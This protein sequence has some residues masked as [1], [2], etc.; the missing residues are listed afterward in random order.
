[1]YVDGYWEN[2][3]RVLG[4]VFVDCKITTWRPCENFLNLSG[5]NG[6][7]GGVAGGGGASGATPPA[8]SVQDAAK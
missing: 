5:L 8:G 3:Q 4:D 2:V 7:K 1:M 6:V